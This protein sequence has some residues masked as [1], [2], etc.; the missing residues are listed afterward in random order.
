MS[1]A[2]ATHSR[3]GVA[4]ALLA[5]AGA[6]F[7]AE[8]AAP[9]ADREFEAIVAS[10]TPETRA[11]ACARM[12]RWV[13]AHARE[14][15]AARGLIWMSQLHRADREPERA[16]AALERV[17]RD[18]PG[19]E[20]ALH[21]EQGLAELDLERHRYESAISRYRELANQAKPLWHYLG[22]NGERNAR[23]ERIRFALV[24]AI[25]LAF[26]LLTLAR[27]RR[28]GLRALWPPPAELVLTLPVLVVLVFASTAQEHDEARAVLF[29]AFGA[30]A[31]L[32]LNGAYLRATAG[33]KRSRIARA[34]VGAAQAAGLLYCALVLNHLWPK[35]MDT[36]A[37]GA[38]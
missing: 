29:V 32:W 38:E 15:L 3:L 10:A 5:L 7:A 2:E 27:L 37:M 8:P 9:G 19:S 24:L 11:E 12:E 36:I 35:L 22:V 31:L 14:P 28:S 30:A 13:D 33:E 21:A 26:A 23:G 25:A 34:L 16:R 18:Y 6:A 4:L 1:R 17:E 20:W